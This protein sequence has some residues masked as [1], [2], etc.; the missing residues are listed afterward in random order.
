MAENKSMEQKLRRTL[1]KLGY[2]LTKS[3]KH[4]WSYDDQGGYMIVDNSINGVVAG[5]HF[6]LSLDDAAAWI[7]Q[8]S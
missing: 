4:N 1:E 3:R 5:S 6:D 7:E 8:N 2:A